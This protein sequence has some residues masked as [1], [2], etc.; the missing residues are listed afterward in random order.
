ME[1]FESKPFKNE[2][3]SI[4]DRTKATQEKSKVEL[5]NIDLDELSEALREY[6]KE[7]GLGATLGRV[8]AGEMID[9]LKESEVDSVVKRQMLWGKI[10]KKFK[11]I[12]CQTGLN[13]ESVEE[14]KGAI[15][16]SKSGIS[17]IYPSEMRINIEKPKVFIDYLSSLDKKSLT[18]NQI[19]GLEKVAGDI[20]S[21]IKDDKT[22]EYL[23]SVYK[24][25]DKIIDCYKELGIGGLVENLESYFSAAKGKYLEEY[26]MV[27]KLNLLDDLGFGPS[28]WHTDATVD[29]YEKK[30]EEALDVL[31]AI[32]QNTKAKEFVKEVIKHLKN[33]A[34]HA[35]A[36]LG[37]RK[38]YD[39]FRGEEF[40]IILNKV[41]D[42]IKTI[43]NKMFEVGKE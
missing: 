6:N 34:E 8:M 40:Q 42:E 24:D 37:N 39:D 10:E 32:S 2:E 25:L 41:L 27:E 43:E 5:K 36:D 21:Q 4:E 33:G 19:D 15:A 23:L 30:W 18:K 29:H 12:L 26:L 7:F 38:I 28:K 35:K 11:N 20:S 9:E 3:K 14:K 31:T 16:S 22:G 17:D 13:L 1:N